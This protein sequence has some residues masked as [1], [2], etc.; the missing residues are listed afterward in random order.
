V[1]MIAPGRLGYIRARLGDIPD[2]APRAAGAR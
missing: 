1:M 2:G